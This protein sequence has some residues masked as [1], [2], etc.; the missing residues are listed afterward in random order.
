LLYTD[1]IHF[2]GIINAYLGDKRTAIEYFTRSL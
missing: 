2:I 1:I